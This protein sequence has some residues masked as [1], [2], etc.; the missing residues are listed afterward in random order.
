[1]IS[2][3]ESGPFEKSKLSILSLRGEEIALRTLLEIDLDLG[4]FPYHNL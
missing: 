4:K 3:Y 1:M 2:V